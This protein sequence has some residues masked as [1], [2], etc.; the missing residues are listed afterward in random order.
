MAAVGHADMMLEA[1]PTYSSA[2]WTRAVS[3]MATAGL[4]SVM[5]EPHL[6]SCGERKPFGFAAATGALANV[7]TEA[8]LACL[9]VERA[10]SA[11]VSTGLP[12][13]A[14]TGWQERSCS[15]KTAA[16]KVWNWSGGVILLHSMTRL[17]PAQRETSVNGAEPMALGIP[18]NQVECAHPQK[19]R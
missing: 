10:G 18:D 1:P 3:V 17:R 2:V 4:A 8:L 15:D 13:G 12:G 11:A 6:D 16:A 5:V 19:V 14:K 7:P 9:L